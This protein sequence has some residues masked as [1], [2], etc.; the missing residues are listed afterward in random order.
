[1]TV[2]TTTSRADYTGNGVTTAFA[3]PFY[4][5]DNSHLIVYRTVISTGVSTTLALGTD[6]TVSGAGVG[7]GGTVTLTV[8]PTALQKISIL[9]NVPLT[10]LV[11]YV[12]NDPFPAATHE[13]ALDQLT[14]EMQQVQEQL[15]R[16]VKVAVTDTT[17]NPDSLISSV[18]TS[19]SNA[20]ASAT[21][22]Q[23]YLNTFKG[24]YYGSLSAD[25]AL[26]PLG[27]AI[28]AGDLYFNSTTLRM[29]VYNGTAWVDTGVATPITVNVQRFS[30]NASTTVFTLTNPPAFQNAAEVFISGVRQVPGVDYTV[31]GVTLNTLTFTTAPPTGTNNVFVQTLSAY[32]GGVPNDGSVTAAKMATG[33]AVANIGAGGITNNELASNAVTTAKIA[34]ANVTTAK[35]ADANVTPAKLSQPLTLGTA[36]ATTSGTAIDFTSIPSWAK[37]ITIM[38]NGLSTSGSSPVMIQVGAGSVLTSGYTSITQQGGSVTAYTTGFSLE[39]GGGATFTRS[40]LATISLIGA[41]N[42]VQSGINGNASVCVYTSGGN[43]A[44]AG[45][46]DR[47]RITTVGGTDTFDAGT[48]NILYE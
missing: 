38:F 27:A 39:T 24:Q 46:L 18:V 15:N 7:A 31:T 19:A 3:V 5:L 2:S 23:G 40:G 26:D 29:R 16:S 32:A 45:A 36:V 6:Y 1:M 11:H 4:F 34:D 44:L 13:Q 43:V 30:G 41:N 22:A 14:M 12:P 42:Y 20:A 25:P 33:A 48:I 10:Q 35:I 8:A 28:T 47:V 21:E 17:T 37:R 9:R